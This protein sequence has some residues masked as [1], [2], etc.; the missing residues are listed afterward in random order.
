MHSSKELSRDSFR[1][2]VEGRSADLEDVFPGFDD[3]DRLGIVV[4][5]PCGALG[6]SG[7]L[8]RAITGFYD[9]QRARSESFRIYADYF[10]FHV[11]ERS[12]DY[13]MIDIWP[14]HKEVVVPDDGER[15]LEAINDRAITRLLVP[16]GE[17]G[18]V[19]LRRHTRSSAQN[20]IV[21]ALAYSPDGR[22]PDADVTVRANE[23]TERYVNAVLDEAT[24][25]PAAAREAIRAARA[26]LIT[27]GR[28]T[29]SYRRIELDEAL[30]L[31]VTARAEPAAARAG[32]L[33]G[34]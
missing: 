30:S 19:E 11:G 17:P 27:D 21:T 3:Q 4:R 18:E 9:C 13:N 32:A 12:G 2:A 16:D 5:H 20:R 26:E 22:V 7:L 28:P 1:L 10:L 33:Q 8:L 24:D 31:L 29:E 15:V 34:A 25:V 6:A 14:D 23:V